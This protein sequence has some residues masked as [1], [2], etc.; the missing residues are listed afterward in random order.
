MDRKLFLF[1]LCC[2]FFSMQADSSPCRE[3]VNAKEK[4][5]LPWS[6]AV[7]KVRRAGILSESEYKRWQKEHPDMPSHPER[8]YA[9]HWRGLRHFLGTVFLP[10]NQAM[11][12]VRRAGV[13]SSMEYRDWQKKNPDMPSHPERAYAEHWRG[14]RHFLG[15]AFLPWDQALLKVRSAGSSSM[16]YKR[17]Q[18]RRIQAPFSRL[19]RVS[20]SIEYRRWQMDHSDMP[21]HP[22]DT[23][24][25]HWRG[26]RHFLGTAF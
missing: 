24:A 17:W 10:L 13:S 18:T 15:T 5:F 25:E 4:A 12:K 7:L 21:S 3:A 22:E 2:L 14:W 11:L 9:K 8:T 6:Q 16:E 1:I 23:Y 19:G 26:W 20:S